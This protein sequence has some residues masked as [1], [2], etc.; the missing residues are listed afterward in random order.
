MSLH[1][2]VF[3]PGEIIFLQGMQADDAFLIKEGRIE[4]FRSTGAGETVLATLRPGDIFG[5]MALVDSR[6]RSAGAR[7]AEVVIVTVIPR[8]VLVQEL[9]RSPLIVRTLVERY[10]DIIR[11]SNRRLDR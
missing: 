9:A 3:R 6:P 4:I 2:R 5:E 7:A 1:T 8:R 10:I 11:E